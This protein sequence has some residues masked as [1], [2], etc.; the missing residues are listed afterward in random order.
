MYT[1][2][3]LNG[4]FKYLSTAWKPFDLSIDSILLTMAPQTVCEN[5]DKGINLQ[6]SFLKNYK[7]H[8]DE[9]IHKCSQ[10]M[11]KKTGSFSYLKLHSKI[12]VFLCRFA[13]FSI[14]DRLF[15]VW[16]EY[17]SLTLLVRNVDDRDS[18]SVGIS[19]IIF[20]VT[21]LILLLSCQNMSV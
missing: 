5:T 12:S 21:G 1:F 20:T 15:I 3:A 13:F 19:G 16:H 2:I 10:K 11:W 9:L 4:L 18:T 7:T 14:H 6:N 17:F 8:H